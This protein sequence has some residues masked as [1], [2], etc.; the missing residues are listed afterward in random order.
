M[1]APTTQN[2]IL[3]DRYGRRVDYI[4][5]SI[6]DR[7]DFRCIYCMGENM[8]F[9]PREEVLSLD[10]CERLVKVFVSLGVSKVRITV[11]N[12]WCAKMRYGY[13]TKLASCRAYV[14]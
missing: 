6:T 12:L 9:L 3:I 7:C 4:R 1:L 5:L 14:S 10:E 2:N 13:L 11:V 8:T